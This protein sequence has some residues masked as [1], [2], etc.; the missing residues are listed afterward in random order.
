[1][2]IYFHDLKDIRNDKRFVVEQSDETPA[3][4]K[5]I[6]S[7][8][9]LSRNDRRIILK[10]E[11][12]KMMEQKKQELVRRIQEIGESLIKNAESIVGN[13][14]YVKSINI[15]ADISTTKDL[16]VEVT[17]EFWPEKFIE[18]TGDFVD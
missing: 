17:K 15:Y 4:T 8:K 6:P 13:E 5:H 1:M 16:S 3:S 14:Q 7:V 18:R 11:E 10:S 12:D 9:L 2:K